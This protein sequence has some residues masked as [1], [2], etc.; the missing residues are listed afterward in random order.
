M[1]QA[2]QTPIFILPGNVYDAAHRATVLHM[3][4]SGIEEGYRQCIVDCEKA[5]FTAEI[6]NLLLNLY[7]RMSH[8][9][10]EIVLINVGPSARKVLML[11]H[12]EQLF[13]IRS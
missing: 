1:S 5:T 9:Q 11:T 4:E 6:I 2:P 7:E 3:V 10:G 12:L 13:S 8:V